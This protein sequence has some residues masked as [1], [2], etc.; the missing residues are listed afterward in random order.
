MMTNSQAGK[1]LKVAL[2]VTD[3]VL[4][5]SSTMTKS[6]NMNAGVLYVVATPIGHLGDLSR[7]AEEVLKSVQIVAAEDTRRTRVLLD[8]IGHRAPEFTSL[9]EHNE[10]QVAPR[11]L[12]RLQNG[13]SIALVSDAGT[14]L[15]N[16]PGRTLVVAAHEAGVTVVPIPGPC[17]ITTLL[18]VCPLAC[19][20]FRFVGFLPSKAKE[21]AT[22]LGQLLLEPDAV[23]FLE[24]PHRILSTLN[25]LQELTA[26][27]V[28]LGRELT[29]QFETLYVGSPEEVAE[30]LGDSP[31]GE[32]VGVIEASDAVRVPVAVRTV[33]TSLLK[34]LAPAQAARLAASICGMKKSEVYDLALSLGQRDGH[35]GRNK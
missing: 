20:P 24:A 12:D 29:K 18:S 5:K 23:V 34:E 8:H 32:F 11:L 14:P 27:R 17:A 9:H 21:R 30:A 4:T 1:I 10:H 31:R 3:T 2:T 16:D 35:Q 33:L 28:M 13:A 6:L 26:R 22:Q 7:R 19:S 25:D 15:I